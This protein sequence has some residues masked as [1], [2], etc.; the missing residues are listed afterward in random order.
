MYFFCEQDQALVLPVQQHM[1][2]MLGESAASFTCSGS[3]SPFLSMPDKV[4]EGLE[5][6]AKVGVEKK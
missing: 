2:S 4:A 5:Y 1:A 3:H 6:A